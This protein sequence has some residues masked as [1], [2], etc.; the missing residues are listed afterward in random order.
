V[1]L[2][3]IACGALAGCYQHVIRAEG[4]G[5]EAVDIYKPNA[6]AK[7]GPLEQLESAVWNDKPKASSRSRGNTRSKPD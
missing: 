5:Q 4:P 2:G 1:L 3:A 6:S 7:P